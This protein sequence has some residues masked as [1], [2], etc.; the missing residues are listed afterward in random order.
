MNRKCEQFQNRI[1]EYIDGSLPANKKNE[2]ESHLA[3]CK[4]CRNEFDKQSEWLASSFVNQEEAD[5]TQE[6]KNRL[7]DQIMTAIRSNEQS[8]RAAAYINDYKKKAD[9]QDQTFMESS[10]NLPINSISNKGNRNDR[11]FWRSLPVLSGYAAVLLLVSVTVFLVMDM[12]SPSKRESLPDKAERAVVNE[13]AMMP[14]AV[15]EDMNLDVYSDDSATLPM[16]S[17]EAMAVEGVD[18]TAAAAVMEDDGSQEV[19]AGM[20][21]KWKSFNGRLGD[22]PLDPELFSESEAFEAQGVFNSSKALRILTTQSVEQTAETEQAPDQP[23]DAGSEITYETSAQTS[24]NVS[25]TAVDKVLILTAWNSWDI[26]DAAD[27]LKHQLQEKESEYDIIIL[28]DS[29]GI[30]KIEEMI[31][32][33]EAKAWQEQIKEQKLEDLVWLALIAK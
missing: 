23:E 6:D 31:G 5:L 4:A 10:D 13:E 12:N 1:P 16:I 18:E 30:T 33:E 32:S 2:L 17:S 27:N 26:V 20:V 29:I 15:D 22:L 3:G 19:D 9:I 8:H 24:T 25:H 7:Q 21:D 11:K 28:D 14:A